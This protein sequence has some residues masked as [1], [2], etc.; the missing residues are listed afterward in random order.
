[1]EH[2]GKIHAFVKKQDMKMNM[3]FVYCAYSHA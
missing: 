2:T 3:Q 1:M